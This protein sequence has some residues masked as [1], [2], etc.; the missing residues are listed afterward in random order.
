MLKE[1]PVIFECGQQILPQKPG[2]IRRHIVHR[3]KLIAHKRGGHE[4]N[5]FLRELGAHGMYMTKGG[6]QPIEAVTTL[7]RAP[8]SLSLIV[9]GGRRW[10]HHFPGKRN[11]MLRIGSEQGVQ[12]GGAA[13]GQTH[14]KERFANFLPRDAGIKL[15]VSFQKQT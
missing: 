13:P 8:Y 3:I 2:S 11:S 7:G 14:D 5:T 9:H 12:E 15:A 1:T 4:G 6:R 10:R